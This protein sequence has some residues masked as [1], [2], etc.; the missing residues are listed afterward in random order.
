[1][2]VDAIVL[3][4]V[5]HELGTMQPL[6]QAAE[7][8]ATRGIS[9]H[10]DATQAAGKIALPPEATTVVLSG[11]KLGGPQGIG[12]LSLRSGDPFPALLTGGAQERRRRAGTENV[13]GI[14]G[15]T[16]S[17]TARQLF[18]FKAGT[19]NGVDAPL[20]KPVLARLDANDLLAITAYL[21]SRQVAGGTR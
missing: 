3:Q 16:A 8:A 7:L 6:E 19:R 1:M 2:L 10:V 21:A 9:L 17:Y 13:P 4:G 14:A 5:N 18:D 20:M 12:A 15:R 11:H